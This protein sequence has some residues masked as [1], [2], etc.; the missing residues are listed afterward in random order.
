MNDTIEYLLEKLGKLETQ[1]HYIEQSLQ[2]D[3]L[4]VKRR[5]LNEECVYPTQGY[6]GDVGH[7]V[8]AIEDI[9]LPFG[10]PVKIKTGLSL[11]FPNGYGCHVRD[12]SGLGSKGIHVL[13]GTIECSYRGE[14]IVCLVNLQ[15]GYTHSIKK[16]DR[17]AQLVFSKVPTVIWSDAEFQ[18]TE[19]G[20]NGFGSTGV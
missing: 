18:D 1:V 7:D 15:D 14:Y 9:D 11:Q 6:K 17:I 3:I 12:R 16:G 8:Y 5:K 4:I 2:E 13:A 20:G 19:R 10:K